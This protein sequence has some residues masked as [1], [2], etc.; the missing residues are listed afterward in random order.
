M[1]MN[2]ADRFVWMAKH[3]QMFRLVIGGATLK[4]FGPT[5]DIEL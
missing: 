2:D 1:E 5:G 3:F 4:Y